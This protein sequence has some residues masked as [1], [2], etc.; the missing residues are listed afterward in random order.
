MQNIMAQLRAYENG[1]QQSITCP[2]CAGVNRDG[3][4]F[5]C[6]EFATA[7]IACLERIRVVD[8][9]KVVQAVGERHQNN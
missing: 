9:I 1:D 8:S 5:C 6:W 7:S 2:F 4:K 3:Q